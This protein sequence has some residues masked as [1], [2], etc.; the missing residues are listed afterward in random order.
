MCSLSRAT[1]PMS[2]T[3]ASGSTFLRSSF[4]AVRSSCRWGE[5]RAPSSA[6]ASGC[7]VGER[8]AVEREPEQLGEARLTRAVE[9]RDPGVRQLGAAGLVELDRDAA[10]QPHV[11]LVDAV[12]HPAGGSDGLSGQPPVMMYSETSAASFSGVCSWK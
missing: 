9:A 3:T 11:L 2:K 7:P 8:D 6:S 12:R 10:Q 4:Q 1:P 5:C